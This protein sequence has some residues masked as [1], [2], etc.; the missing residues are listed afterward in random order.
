MF[1]LHFYSYLRVETM[2]LIHFCEEVLECGHFP[3]SWKFLCKQNVLENFECQI[4]QICKHMSRSLDPTSTFYM[5][6]HLK[7]FYV[8]N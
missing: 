8:V 3:K 2:V 4:P 5:V 6:S 7:F 1:I